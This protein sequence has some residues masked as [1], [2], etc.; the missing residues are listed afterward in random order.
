MALLAAVNR[1]WPPGSPCHAV[2]KELVTR[3]ADK[4]KG[5]VAGNVREHRCRP[6]MLLARAGNGRLVGRPGI[7]GPCPVPPR[8]HGTS[9][10]CKDQNLLHFGSYAT[11]P[12]ID[13]VR[14][15]TPTLTSYQGGCR[16]AR[17]AHPCW[18]SIRQVKFCTRCLM[19][20][21][22]TRCPSSTLCSALKQALAPCHPPSSSC[23]MGL[24]L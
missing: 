5:K 16:N 13:P 7:G 11:F 19:R 22:S 8:S 9:A 21:R 14:S 4:M 15:C 2:A 17:A 1:T 24:H 6:C 12:V 23:S 10:C 20:Q 3:H 18:I